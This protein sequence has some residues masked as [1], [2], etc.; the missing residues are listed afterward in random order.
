MINPTSA[1][2]LKLNLW[3]QL[4]IFRHDNVTWSWG[5]WARAAMYLKRRKKK[6]QQLYPWA[7][8]TKMTLGAEDY[9]LIYNNQWRREKGRKMPEVFSGNTPSSSSGHL[10][11]F[12]PASAPQTSSDSLMNISFLVIP[13]FIPFLS[14]PPPPHS[15]II[16][17]SVS[18]TSHLWSSWG[19]RCGSVRRVWLPRLTFLSDSSNPLIWTIFIITWRSVGESAAAYRQASCQHQDTFLVWE[20]R[21]HEPAFVCCL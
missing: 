7:A 18:V 19:D 15:L 17:L 14:P 4:S 6:F 2:P 12:R 1:I 5:K 21:C 8:L 16:C 11:I 13:S 9:G 10:M 3:E 20:R